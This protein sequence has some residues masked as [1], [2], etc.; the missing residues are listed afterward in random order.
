[1][2]DLS[3]HDRHD[4]AATFMLPSPGLFA[5]FE[6]GTGAVQL[7]DEFFELSSAVQLEILA[8]WRKALTEQ[9]NK[10]LVKL[11]RDLSRALPEDS[12]ERRIERFRIT[13]HTLGI[14]CPRDMASLLGQAR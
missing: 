5:D 12:T 8:G 1:M 2:D 3:E 14:E 9:W 11:F 6:M 7:P 4:D 13:C 10:T